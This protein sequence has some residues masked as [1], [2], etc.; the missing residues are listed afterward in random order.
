MQVIM[1]KNYEL[2]I[3]EKPTSAKKIAE[4]LAD[5]KAPTN[6]VPLYKKA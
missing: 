4:A 3:A 5:T 2:L 6:I 1:S